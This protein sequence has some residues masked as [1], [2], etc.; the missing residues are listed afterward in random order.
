M[1]ATT[2]TER[3]V[4]NGNILEKY[5]F[6]KYVVFASTHIIRPDEVY[7][8]RVLGPRKINVRVNGSNALANACRIAEMLDKNHI[9]E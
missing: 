7:D 9:Q 5:Q 3:I 6:G 8:V 2:P 1:I 4:E